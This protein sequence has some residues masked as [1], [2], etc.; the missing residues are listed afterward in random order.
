MVKINIESNSNLTVSKQ[1]D[2]IKKF[3]KYYSEFEWPKDQSDN[4]RFYLSN[5]MYSY[6]DSLMLYSIMRHYKP[7]RIIEAGSGFTS[8]LML[9]INDRFFNSNISFSFIDPNPERLFSLLNKDD[10]DNTIIIKGKLQFQDIEIFENLNRNDILFVDSSHVSKIGSDVNHYLFNIFPKL[11]SGVIIH[12]HDISWPFEYPKD[13]INSGKS[14]NEAY[15]IRAFLQ[16][17]NSFEILLYNSYLGYAHNE[18]LTK[19]MPLFTKNHGGSLWL[20]KI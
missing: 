7:K 6:G 17:N 3:A 19:E 2:L 11:K 10:Q 5:D 8:A 16:Y 1:L 20:R 13:V 12:I 4:F 18:I 9:D 15:A 14:W